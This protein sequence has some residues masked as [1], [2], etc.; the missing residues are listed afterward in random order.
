MAKTQATESRVDLLSTLG[1]DPQT[2]TNLLWDND[3]KAFQTNFANSKDIPIDT[4]PQVLI[5]RDAL[6]VS[7]TEK[8]VEMAGYFAKLSFVSD[9]G[10]SANL[11][12]DPSST[13]SFGVQA[14]LPI[15]EGWRRDS[16]IHEANSRIHA[17][18]AQLENTKRTVTAEVINQQGLIEKSRALLN[19][20][21]TEE[22][23]AQKNLELIHTRLEN[24]IGNEEE[25]SSA[26]AQVA[27]SQNQKEEAIATLLTAQINLAHA[28]GRIDE[29]FV[30]QTKE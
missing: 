10:L 18:E 22:I 7:K 28:Q 25:L 13:Y 19:Q 3:P 1:I 4:H 24:G 14:T 6:A 2:E 9:Y 27:Y 30:T 11:P 26:Q 21:E 15:F 16:R 5:A 20:K 23:L 17:D 29:I 12:S 8:Q